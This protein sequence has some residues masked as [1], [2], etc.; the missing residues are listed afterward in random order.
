MNKVVYIKSKI[1]GGHYA[2]QSERSN[3]PFTNPMN[4]CMKV[5][6]YKFDVVVDI[7]AYV[8]EYSLYASNQNVKI[9]YAYEA[10]PRTYKVLKK[11]SKD[12]LIAP[13]NKAVVGDNREKATLFISRGI[14]VTN[15]IVKS[16]GDK[17]KVPAIRY[18][19]AVKKATVVK[20]DVE[21]A[22]YSYDIIQPNIR[23]I[24]LEFHP[25]AKENWKEK[26]EQI[27]ANMK[28][29]GFKAIARPRFKHGWDLIGCWIR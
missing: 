11:N 9:V 7:G 4:T 29:E 1:T 6:L 28:S 20:I 10:T 12:T 24:I 2:F 8:G 15:S 26:A 14:G 16:K 25:L 17:I 19:D 5:H 27:M 3:K 21:G 13:I 18:E 23:A 22:E